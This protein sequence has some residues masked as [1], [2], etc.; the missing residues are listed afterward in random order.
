MRISNKVGC[1]VSECAVD[2]GLDSRALL[3]A[4]PIQLGSRCE[5]ARLFDQ[6]R[7]ECLSVLY[8]ACVATLD[9]NQ[10]DSANCCFDSHSI[11]VTGPASGVVNYSYDEDKSPRSYVYAYN[12]SGG[13]TLWACA[14]P[15]KAD[16]ISIFYP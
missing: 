12:E 4:R 11:P 13:V 1:E 16:D 8:S 6:T 10:A 2:L 14:A 7:C 9:E 3:K 5:V 15:R